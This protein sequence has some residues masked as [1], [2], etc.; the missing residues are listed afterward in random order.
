MQSTSYL[1]FWEGKLVHHKNET[2]NQLEQHLESTWVD[3]IS[4]ISTCTSKG[5]ELKFC[6]HVLGFADCKRAAAAASRSLRF[7]A[8]YTLCCPFLLS[9]I[10]GYT[11]FRLF[12][13]LEWKRDTEV[14]TVFSMIHSDAA[15]AAVSSVMLRSLTSPTDWEWVT[16]WPTGL[17]LFFLYVGWH[18]MM[19]QTSVCRHSF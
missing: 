5:I 15:A 17:C 11:L 1:A 10:S 2:Q 6:W 14:S 12:S 18:T 8:F 3:I 4:D 13:T 16:D 9:I 7:A 19:W